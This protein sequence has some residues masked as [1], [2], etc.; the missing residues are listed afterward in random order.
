MTIV[1][2]PPPTTPAGVLLFQY[3]LVRFISARGII[4]PGEGILEHGSILAQLVY[5]AIMAIAGQ[6]A[7][8]GSSYLFAVSGFATLSIIILNDLVLVQGEKGERKVHYL[9]YF[10][11]EVSANPVMVSRK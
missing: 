2:L 11:A 6:S 3:A 10:L 8:I 1:P 9:C 4:K 5:N 7:R